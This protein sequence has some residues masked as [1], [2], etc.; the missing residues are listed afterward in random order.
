MDGM[1]YCYFLSFI[2]SV[3][4]QY[5]AVV[6]PN[7]SMPIHCAL[8]YTDC[9]YIG[10]SHRCSTAAEDL[11]RRWDNPCP[12]LHP[13]IYHTKG[14]LQYMQMIGKVPLVSTPISSLLYLILTSLEL[15]AHGCNYWLTSLQSKSKCRLN[16]YNAVFYLWLKGFLWLS[17]SLSE[18]EHFYLWLLSHAVL[19]TQ[20]HQKPSVYWQ[21]DWR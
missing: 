4:L 7:M 8:W 21:Q 17:W 16:V 9:W 20:R 18:E 19:Y 1:D 6:V 11:N 12:R 10:F 13:T 2:Q 15:S 14:L 5:I 3:T